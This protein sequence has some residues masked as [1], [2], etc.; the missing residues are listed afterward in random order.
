[1]PAQKS[2]LD[3]L[4]IYLG[5]IMPKERAKQY[6]EKFKQADESIAS[7]AIRIFEGRAK[8]SEEDIAR[9]FQ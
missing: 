4:E 6:L 3:T 2:Q 9:L 8:T 5:M 1:M 7:E